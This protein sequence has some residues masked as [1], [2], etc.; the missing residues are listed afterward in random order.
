[1]LITGPIN[2]DIRHFKREMMKHFRMSDLGL[3]TYYLGM[4]VRQGGHGI[5]LCQ[6]SS[7]NPPML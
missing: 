5:S 2:D 7:V 3:L 6:S 4:E 1:M